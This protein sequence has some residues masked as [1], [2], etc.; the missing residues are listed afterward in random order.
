M[1]SR[2]DR[3]FPRNKTALVECLRKEKCFSRKQKALT[4]VRA[5]RRVERRCT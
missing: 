1:R 3:A 4:H 5:R 2:S